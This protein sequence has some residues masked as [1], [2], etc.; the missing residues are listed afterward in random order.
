MEVEHCI[1][2]AIVLTIRLFMFI[3]SVPLVV[4]SVHEHLKSEHE[5]NCRM[6]NG[7]AMRGE[8]LGNF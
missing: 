6:V 5:N 1:P 3:A 2:F 4:H 8:T 7:W